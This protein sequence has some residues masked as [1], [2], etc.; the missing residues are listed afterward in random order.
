MRPGEMFVEKSRSLEYLHQLRLMALLREMV[1]SFRT[2]ALVL[3]PLQIVT[4]LDCLR[5]YNG[6]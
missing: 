5:W 1:R 6:L 2:A 4:G 3:M